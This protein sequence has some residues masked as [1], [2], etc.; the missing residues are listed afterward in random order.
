MELGMGIGDLD[1]V[2]RGG[3]GGVVVGGTLGSCAGT[4]VGIGVL[5][6]T[7]GSRTWC[8]FGTVG[9][10]RTVG[11]TVGTLGSCAEG[12][13]VSVLGGTDFS[14]VVL[15]MSLSCCKIVRVC[16]DTGGSNGL[17]SCDLIAAVRSFAAAMMILSCEGM[18]IFIEL[19]G[20][21]FTVLAIHSA[22]V[23]V[24]HTQWQR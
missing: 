19:C 17:L 1:G 22:A 8:S 2:G 7:L 15:K 10:G 23:L 11:I 24:I 20:S 14:M 21:H 16:V 18:G 12:S 4:G 6:G 3:C 5:D 13:L 9:V